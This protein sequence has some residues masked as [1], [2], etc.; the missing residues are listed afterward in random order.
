MLSNFFSI[1]L[2]Y[3]IAKNEKG[4]WMAFNRDFMPLG[5]NDYANRHTYYLHTTMRPPIHTAYENLTEDVLFSLA[6]NREDLV[7]RSE[8][9]V[10][11]VLFYDGLTTPLA[12][13]EK[14]DS[15]I[16]KLEILSKLNVK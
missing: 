4:E 13:H 5:V 15:Y 7:R 11:R 10:I 2:P 16:K 9:Q 6:D 3:G 14:W 8:G 1:N 12:G